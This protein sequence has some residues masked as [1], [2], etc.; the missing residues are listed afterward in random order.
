MTLELRDEAST[1]GGDGDGN[2]ALSGPFLDYFNERGCRVDVDEVYRD[3]YKIDFAVSRIDGIHA[4][5][6]LGVHLTRE[7]DNFSQQEVLLEAARKGVV[8]RSIYIEMCSPVLDTGVVPVTYGACLGYLF[9]RR[10]QHTRTVGLRVFEDCSF[11]YFD[12]EENVRR[13]RK[14]VHDAEHDAAELMNGDI[15]AYF[16]DKGFG[17]IEEEHNQKFF[18]HIANVIDEKLRLALP[19]YVQG[20]TI[21]VRFTYGGSE[22]KKYPKAVEVRGANN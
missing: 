21:P 7:T 18:F 1:S 10:Y 16:S 12:L 17:F 3:R 8:A 22:G 11:H 20:D 2:T 9:D 15:I 19:G 6:S 4:A 13:L 14:D 5:V